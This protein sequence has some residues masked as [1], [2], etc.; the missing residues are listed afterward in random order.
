MRKGERGSKDHECG[1]KKSRSKVLRRNEQKAR[2]RV[3]R[4]G[5]DEARIV[6]KEEEECH[7][8]CNRTGPVDQDMRNLFNNEDVRI[9]E[10]PGFF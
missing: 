9:K 5:K 7:Y 8:G 3:K 10:K 1:H 4:S 6:L 2:R